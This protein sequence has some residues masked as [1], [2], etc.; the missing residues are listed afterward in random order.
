LDRKKNVPNSA[1]FVFSARSTNAAASVPVG[2]T[3]WAKRAIPKQNEN[4]EQN[5]D[6]GSKNKHLQRMGE[7][8]C[9]SHKLFSPKHKN[10]E[11]ICLVF[12]G[13]TG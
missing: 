8:G 11:N 10:G 12:C 5:A 7:Q 4:A 6:G 9:L 13:E 1:S 2:R 3:F